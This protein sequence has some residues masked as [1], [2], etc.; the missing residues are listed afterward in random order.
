MRGILDDPQSVALSKRMHGVKVHHQP[1]DVDRNHADHCKIRGD[2]SPA[3]SQIGELGLGIFEVHVQRH[4][5]AVDQHGH[6]PLVAN[7][8]GRCGEGHRGDQH[9]LPGAQ[10]HRFDGQ[11]QGGGARVDSH[12]MFR[13]NG[14]GKVAFKPLDARSRGQPTRAKAFDHSAISASPIDG[15]K[16][17]TVS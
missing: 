8:F 15:R 16:N 9:G 1:A 7:H 4:R 2:G 5:I 11:M 13:P 3:G 14:L 10:P 17:G 6:G 12:G